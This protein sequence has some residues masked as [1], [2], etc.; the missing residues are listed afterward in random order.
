MLMFSKGADTFQV[1]GKKNGLSILFHSIINDNQC[2]A[3]QLQSSFLKVKFHT[4]LPALPGLIWTCSS[5]CVGDSP[6]RCWVQNYRSKA[7]M[8]FVKKRPKRTKP[9]RQH[10]TEPKQ[11]ESLISLTQFWQILTLAHMDTSWG[12]K[13]SLCWNRISNGIQCKFLLHPT[14]TTTVNS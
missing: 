13:D 14:T 1:C 7:V 2:R 3:G 6:W 12:L 10:Q 5:R 9:P 8:I 11:K 4:S